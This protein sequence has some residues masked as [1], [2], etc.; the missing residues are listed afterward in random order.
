MARNGLD[1]LYGESD[2]PANAERLGVG[3]TDGALFEFMRTRIATLQAREEP[4]FLAALTSSMHHP[5]TIP[6]R[7]PEVRTLQRNKDR[8]I[9]ALRYFDAEFESFFTS[10]QRAGLLRN[11]MVIVM[12]DH[13]RHEPVGD[14]D[15]ERQSGRFLV[16]LIIWLDESLQTPD[17]YHPRHIERIASQVDVAPTI[18]AVNGMMPRISPFVGRDLSCLFINDCLSDN[19]AYLSN[20]YDDQ[21]GLTDQDGLWI[22]S[23]RRGVFQHIGLKATGQAQPLPDPASNTPPR[24]RRLIALYV[25]TNMLPEKKQVWSWKDLEGKL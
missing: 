25:T 2:F 24:Y 19:T 1:Q 22:Y 13:G 18:L 11:T 9:P 23:F 21:I 6:L 15:V 5:F 12:G 17:R 3:L 16:P 7:H 14:T 10:L 8:Y 20:I 4:F